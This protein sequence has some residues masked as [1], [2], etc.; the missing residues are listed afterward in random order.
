[1]FSPQTNSGKLFLASVV[2]ATISS[3]GYLAMRSKNN[4]N[5]LQLSMAVY[6]QQSA[7]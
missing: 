7:I 4:K 6:I 1:M 3:L 2:I 5:W